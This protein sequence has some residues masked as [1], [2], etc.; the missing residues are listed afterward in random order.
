MQAGA[1]RTTLITTHLIAAASA[2]PALSVPIGP[3][4]DEG[5]RKAALEWCDGIPYRVLQWIEETSGRPEVLR[6][7]PFS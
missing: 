3:A 1:A 4:V 5:T 6:F 2:C 7:W